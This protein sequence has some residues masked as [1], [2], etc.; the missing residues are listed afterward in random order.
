VIIKH[1]VPVTPNAGDT[2]ISIK[3]RDLIREVVPDAD[4]ITLPAPLTKG[5]IDLFKKPDIIVIG[6][7]PLYGSYHLDTFPGKV[8]IPTYLLG[9]GMMFNKREKISLEERL[10]RFRD[11]LVNIRLASTREMNTQYRLKRIGVDSRMVG[12]PVMHIARDTMWK[13]LKPISKKHDT[14]LFNFRDVYID[15]KLAL[16]DSKALVIANELGFQNSLLVSHTYEAALQVPR[17]IGASWM[18]QTS[19]DVFARILRVLKRLSSF[20]CIGN[21]IHPVI[22]RLLGSSLYDLFAHP[23]GLRFYDAYSYPL[24]YRWASLLV[25][26]QLHAAIAAA[27]VGT[28]FLHVFVE[29]SNRVRDMI[30]TYDPNMKLHIPTG[31]STLENIKAKAM[32][33]LEDPDPLREYRK[34]VDT[35]FEEWELFKKD[36]I[37]DLNSL[38]LS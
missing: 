23:L 21:H 38:G 22:H 10:K 24:L 13:N 8:E 28:P 37:N 27:A 17:P 34:R 14:L 4:I 1:F 3:S 31:N 20:R 18:Q 35:A 32:L 6:G 9:I 33:I 36:M 5:K 19:L 2:L 15:A 7:G 16:D 30:E 26:Y 12:C 29:E 25:T 11:S